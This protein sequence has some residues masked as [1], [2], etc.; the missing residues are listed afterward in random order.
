MSFSSRI[1]ARL[2]ITSCIA[3]C[4]A[5]GWLYLKQSRVQ[6][7]LHERSLLQQAREISEYLSV[8]GSGQPE[9]NLAP[10]MYEPSRQH[11]SVCHPG[12]QRKNRGEVQ[13][14]RGAA[15]GTFQYQ[16]GTRMEEENCR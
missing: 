6:E 8:N 2:T 3:A 5:Y 9:L 14:S 1:I 10:A 4:I 16:G 15:N 12:R 11:I 7:H 13:R